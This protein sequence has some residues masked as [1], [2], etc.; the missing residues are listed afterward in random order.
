MLK[1]ERSTL[2]CADRCKGAREDTQTGVWGG[3]ALGKKKNPVSWALSEK[4]EDFL[5]R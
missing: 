1:V 2:W 3:K 5:R 4:E